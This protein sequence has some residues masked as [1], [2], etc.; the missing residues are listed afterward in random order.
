M[1]ELQSEFDVSERRACDVV[2][3]PRSSQRYQAKPRVDEP[4][5]VKRMLELVGDRPRFGYRRIAWQL[6]EESFEASD[7]R[8]Y[9]L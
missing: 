3:Q 5:L 1:K 8:V 4:A 9:R 7:T 2:G 6:R